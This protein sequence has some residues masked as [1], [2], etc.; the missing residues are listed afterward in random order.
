MEEVS[1]A[2]FTWC[3]PADPDAE[4][5]NDAAECHAAP[6]N[7]GAESGNARPYD[8]VNDYVSSYGV[9]QPLPI[10]DVNGSNSGP[11]NYQAWITI[12]Q[13]SLGGIQAADSL[14]IRIRVAYGSTEMAVLDGYRT[15]Y[16]P[17]VL[18]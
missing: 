12:S 16:A 1:L 7:V 3:D 8:N 18:P 9:E 5:A 15:R 14:H 17:N 10:L 4:T 13:E 2:K 11:A 6:E